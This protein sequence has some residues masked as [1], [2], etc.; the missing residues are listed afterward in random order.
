MMTE[1]APIYIRPVRAPE[2]FGISRSTLY[3]WAQ[4]GL[5]R[6]YRRGSMSFVR[7]EEVRA[8]IEAEDETV[9]AGPLAGE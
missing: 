7:V 9:A 3:R 5:I 1:R 2:V 4:A 6:I 8:V